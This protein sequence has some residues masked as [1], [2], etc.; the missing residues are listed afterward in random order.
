MLFNRDPPH[1]MQAVSVKGFN[2]VHFLQFQLF[3]SGGSSG[4]FCDFSFLSDDF[5]LE[6]TLSAGI[7]F[8]FLLRIFS[9]LLHLL[10]SSSSSSEWS[11]LY[12]SSFL[13]PDFCFLFFCC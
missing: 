13:S 12:L 5:V 11:S 7:F 6:I 2:K 4:W 10:S 8:E 1:A 9:D 3:G